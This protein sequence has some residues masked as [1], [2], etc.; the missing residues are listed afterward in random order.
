VIATEFRNKLF[1]FESTI[2][3]FL[4]APQPVERVLEKPLET[5]YIGWIPNIDIYI[6]GA[7]PV[8]SVIAATFLKKFFSGL[9]LVINSCSSAT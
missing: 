3:I 4:Y 5:M 7:Q 6:Y 2:G 8:E 1:R 9:T